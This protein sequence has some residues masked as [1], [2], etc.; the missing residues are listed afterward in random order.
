MSNDEV[1][2]IDRILSRSKVT[3]YSVNFPIL[4]TCKPTE[5]CLKTCYFSVGLN[6]SKSSLNHQ[7]NNYYDCIEDP[8][9]FANQ[10]I[11]E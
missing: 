9:S 5:V 11:R 1:K 4:K 6:T 3:G 2:K 10:I 7:L 8:I